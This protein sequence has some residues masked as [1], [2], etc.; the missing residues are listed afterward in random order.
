MS[1]VDGLI[2]VTRTGT[3][4]ERRWREV[5]TS[6]QSADFRQ[7]TPGVSCAYPWLRHFRMG[8]TEIT[9]FLSVVTSVAAVCPI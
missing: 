4:A 9:A 3:A 8:V 1:K 6:P 5:S 2:R 7:P